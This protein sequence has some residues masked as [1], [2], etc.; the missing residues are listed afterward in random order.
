MNRNQSLD[1][2]RGI[3]IFLVII[4]HYFSNT[5]KYDGITKILGD[6]DINIGIIG[7]MGVMLFFFLSGFL[8]Y[9]SLHNTSSITKF[10]KKRFF[11]IYPPY[12]FSLIFYIIVAYFIFGFLAKYDFRTYLINAF[13]L[14]DIFKVDLVVGV[15]WSLLIEIKFYLIIAILYFYLKKYFKNVT[16]IFFIIMLIINLIVFFERGYGSWLLIWMPFFWV[17]IYLYIYLEKKA[18]SKQKFF[19]I[20]IVLF[21]YYFLLNEINLGIFLVLNILLFLCIYNFHYSNKLLSFYGLISYSFYLLHTIISYP[22]FY[23]LTKN[24]IKDYFFIK[25]LI[26]FLLSSIISYLSFKYIENVYFK[27]KELI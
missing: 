1:T 23:W 6:Y 3:A 13:M 15:Y 22:L 19:I 9:H 14:Q 24:I 8:I 21:F 2:I 11:R 25:I 27:L 18:M 20:G 12:L 26:A 16:D 17:G 5:I 4:A 10:Y 7:R